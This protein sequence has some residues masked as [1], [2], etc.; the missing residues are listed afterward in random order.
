MKIQKKYKKEAI[1]HLSDVVKGVKHVISLIND[2][3]EI[4][5]EDWQKEL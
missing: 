3:K 1:Q 4:N 5:N 2:E